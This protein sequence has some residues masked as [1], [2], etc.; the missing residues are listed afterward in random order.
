[1]PGGSV[2]LVAYGYPF[3]PDQK[4]SALPNIRKLA[5]LAT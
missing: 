5:A 2:S 4:L 1:M 3:V